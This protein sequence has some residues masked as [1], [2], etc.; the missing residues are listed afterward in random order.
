MF[1][2]FRMLTLVHAVRQP[3]ARP[4]VP[5]QAD[6]EPA[7]RDATFAIIQRLIHLDRKSTGRLDI[8]ASWQE[9][10]DLGPGQTRPLPVGEPDVV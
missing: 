10:V 3:L 9:P 7:G 2:P 8:L 6:R 5:H 4:R 1:E